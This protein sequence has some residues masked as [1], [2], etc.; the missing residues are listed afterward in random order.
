MS[1]KRM[2]IFT[3]VILS[4]VVI[5]LG[6]VKLYQTYALGNYIDTASSA[7]FDV[8]ITKDTS[9]RIPANGYSNVFYMVTNTSPGTVRYGVAYTTDSAVTVKTFSTSND[10]AS[11]LIEENGKKYVKLR[12]ENSSSTSQSV[13][14]STVLGYSGDSNLLPPSGVTLV[15]EVYTP[16]P[17]AQYVTG[18]YTSGT[19]TP[20]TN[21]GKEYNT[22]PSVSLMNDRLGGTTGDLDGGNIRYYGAN[23]NNYIYFNCSGYPSTNCELWRIIGI[24]GGKTKII[25]NESIGEYSWDNKN[26]STGAETDTGKNDWTTARLMKLLNPVDYYIND[27][28]DKDSEGNYLGYSLYYNSAPGKCYSGQNNA[29]VD[30]DFTSTGIKNDE[31]RNMIA[32]TTWNIGG[33]NSSSV[34]PNQI[35]EY[36]RGTT[37]YTGR[38]TTPWTGKIGLMYPSDYGYATD[39]TKCSQNLLNYNSST[40]SYACR[41]NDWLYNSANQWSLTPCS[42]NSVSAWYVSSSGYVGDSR[43]VRFAYG[44]RPVLYLD[45]GVLLEMGNGTESN[46]YK[47]SGGSSSNLEQPIATYTISYNANNGTGA[48]GDQ[49]KTQN[50]NLTLSDTIPTRSGYKFMGWNTNSD[51]S[52][53]SYA[54][55]SSYTEN[56]SVTLYAQW[57]Q[58][59]T[60]TYDANNGTGAPSSQ[61]KIAGE[62]ITLSNTIPTRSNYEF[63][64]W[65]TNSDGSG[66]SYAP[67]ATYSSDSDVTLYAKWKQI[68]TISY[69]ANGGSGVP[70]SQ[71]KVY[72]TSITLSSTTPTKTGYTFTDWNTSSDGTGTSYAP[73]G[74]YSAN[75]NITLY[76][77]WRI[78][79]VLIKLSTNGGVLS[80]G[81]GYFVSDDIV[82]NQG[83]NILSSASYDGT[84]ISTG[85]P[86]YNN[87]SYLNITKPSSTASS[88]AEWKC[89]SGCT[90]S[91]KTFNQDTVY[92]ASDFC[93][94]ASGDCTVTLGV[95]W[96]SSPTATFYPN[97]GKFSTGAESYSIPVVIGQNYYFSDLDLPAITK[98][99]CTLDGWHMN[100]P[101]G[102]VYRSYFYLESGDTNINFYANWS[103]SSG[104]GSTYTAKFYPNGGTFSTGA[105]SWSKTVNAGQ[106][107]YFS[108]IGIPSISKS[109][110]SLDGW[111]DGS[112]YGTVYRS[113]FYLDSN[114]DFYAN[115]SC[116][117][118]CQYV[119]KSQPY[120]SSSSANPC[121]STSRVCNGTQAQYT[122][123]TIEGEYVYYRQWHYVC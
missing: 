56:E 63:D 47:I 119:T 19:K 4:V 8:N 101:G 114:N 111:H 107:Y 14:L 11:G 32:E 34:Y 55:G 90:T 54:S 60:I 87:T 120:Y 82:Y 91:G 25:R 40:D 118:S 57:K 42:S 110:C 35:Y 38:P 83:S 116:S 115:W 6:I 71:S 33:W 9:V 7:T 93:D 100:S 121:S 16:I 46:P 78:N 62:A 122:N 108:S 72:G 36:E 95:N 45:A 105:S 112:I 26:T 18:L 65:N 58:I 53:T 43:G 37:V 12:L 15:T 117:C 96:V 79:M 29:T 97:E 39:F 44:V 103:C 61:T 59:F 23:P 67:G 1:K 80:S 77:Q 81:S 24:F 68:Y 20:A 5:S 88:G 66:A 48:P 28:N 10:P 64:G 102:T 75:E 94:S 51:G 74:S 17:L 13:V 106:T 3:S 50:I 89:L 52:G 69:N 70:S 73:G 85:L 27:N 123:C 98:S 22:A 104:S 86:D 2:I 84:L 31:T 109:N 92:N 21:N 99:N 30:C 76:A 113:Y 49:I 41:T